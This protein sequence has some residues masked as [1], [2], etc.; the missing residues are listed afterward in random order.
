MNEYASYISEKL[1]D[2]VDYYADKSLI[3]AM[4]AYIKY[5]AKKDF[6][7]KFHDRKNRYYTNS[8][9]TNVINFEGSIGRDYRVEFNKYIYNDS[10]MIVKG[11]LRT[12]SYNLERA[13][14]QYMTYK[15][16]MDIVGR[17]KSTGDEKLFLKKSLELFGITTK[18]TGSGLELDQHGIEKIKSLD[19]YSW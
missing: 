7:K 11:V 4:V 19:G 6:I 3:D 1:D 2:S 8:E 9:E 12:C 10:E 13:S 15:E 17:Y 14:P 18:E 5:A 16:Y